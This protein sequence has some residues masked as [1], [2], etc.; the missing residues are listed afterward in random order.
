MIRSIKGGKRL[1]FPIVLITVLAL[2]ILAIGGFTFKLLK[3]QRAVL[4]DAIRES[5]AQAVAL[6]SEKVEQALLSAIRPAF[7]VL[8]NIPHKAVDPNVWTKLKESAPEL[9]QILFLDT[10]LSVRGS[11]PKA[12]DFRQKELDAWVAER[13]AFEGVTTRKDAFLLHT[14]IEKINSRPTLFAVQSA[15]EV[16]PKAGWLLLQFDLN[17]LRQSR[18]ENVFRD[19]QRSQGGD[20]KLQDPETEWDD[21]ALNWPVGRVLPGWLVVY[22]P[23]AA[24]EEA[25]LSYESSLVLGI[26]GGVIFAILMAGFSLWREVRR[27][28]ALVDLRNRFVANV[29]H[30]LRTPLA[31]IR[32]Y[33]ETLYLRRIIEPEKQHEY[34]RTILRETERLGQMIDTVLDFARLNQGVK[35]Y[36]LQ[37]LDLAGTVREVI[38]RY[39]NRVREAGLH[40]EIKIPD[41]V[42]NVLHDRRGVTQILLNLMDNAIK[43]GA[44]GGE[45]LV[46]L[47]VDGNRVELVVSD[48]GPGIPQEERDRVRRPFE[49]GAEADPSTG[50]GLGLSLVDQIAQAHHALLVLGEKSPGQGLT[51]SV[52]FAV[53]ENSP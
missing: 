7:L 44:E 11:L 5:D 23:D 22:R 27:E 3:A 51:A 18:L 26:T 50:S 8:K 36:N 30:E 53:E 45:V 28:Y 14:F 15:N 48:S 4:E 47:L 10:D 16:D 34:H 46:A 33:A 17:A 49:R 40:L 1:R 41:H 21:G 37:D 29:S 38:E 43:Y 32:M 24:A 2:L 19:F 42:P 20:L 9:E 39:G 52:S 13:V 25:S 35:L 31:L 6:I 12:T